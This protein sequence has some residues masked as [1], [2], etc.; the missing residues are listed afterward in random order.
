MTLRVTITVPKDAGNYT[1]V[2]SQTNGNPDHK[3]VP[4][5]SLDV[6]VHSGNQITVKEAGPAATEDFPLGAPANLC[7]DT[8]CD[9]CQ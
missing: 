7:G 2:V 3:L 1:A 9:S 5:T 8:T 4:G 6:W